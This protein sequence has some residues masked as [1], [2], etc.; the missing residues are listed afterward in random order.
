MHIVVIGHTM[1]LFIFDNR[2][3]PAP[4][5]VGHLITTDMDSRQFDSGARIHVDDT[6][7]HLFKESIG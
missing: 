1:L 3:G 7:I 5:T 4:G 6:V 2:R